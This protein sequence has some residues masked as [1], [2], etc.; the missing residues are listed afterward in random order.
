[1][2]QLLT[3]HRTDLRFKL[4]S[5]GATGGEPEN[6]QA[7]G[8]GVN[9]L[10]YGSWWS[11]VYTDAQSL[12]LQALWTQYHKNQTD[13]RPLDYRAACAYEV[14]QQIVPKYITEFV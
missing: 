7:L 13:F 5:Y 8:R 11:T 9:G 6:V 14:C 4:K 12:R 1:M 3:K 10:V 2:T